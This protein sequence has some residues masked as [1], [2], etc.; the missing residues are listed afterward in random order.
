[1]LLPAFCLARLAVVEKRY[2]PGVFLLAAIGV[3]V[4]SVKDL[5]GGNFSAVALWWGCVTWSAAALLVGSALSLVTCRAAVPR[6]GFKV[7]DRTVTSALQ[8]AA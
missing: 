6:T 7:A 3:S 1:M 5:W 4:P 2:L 8:K